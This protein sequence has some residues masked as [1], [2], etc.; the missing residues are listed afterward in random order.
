MEIFMQH[1][2]VTDVRA[3]PGDSA[4]LIDNG[5]TAV[6][7]DSGFAFT[8]ERVAQNIKKCLGKRQLDY[9]FLTHS[10]YDH[11]LGSVYVKKLYPSVIV[12]A[13][14]YAAKIFAKTS[15]R[16]V[17][18]DLDGK[19]AKK[20]GVFEYEDLIDELSVDIEVNDGDVISAGD[21]TFQVVGLPGHTKCSVGYFLPENRLL[22]GTE[23]LGVYGGNNVVV[24]SYLV[25]FEMTLNSI[26]KARKLDV[27]NILVP[28]YGL[29]NK[30]ESEEYLK[31]CPIS[32]QS[33]ANAISAILKNGGT[34]AEA[35]EYFERTFYHGYIKEI[36]PIDAMRLN[37]NI[38]INLVKNEF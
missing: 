38:M 15:A 3:L 37:T 22:L 4:F 23:T 29:L 11:S 35:L 19:F 2:T 1:I 25:G 12:V 30:F 33:T 17:M 27:E 13:G 6:L 7:Y 14:S 18:R 21:M 26:S 28:H 20:C 16:A 10:H 31:L 9:I 36:Y 34:S 32:A 5:K 24:P 8:G